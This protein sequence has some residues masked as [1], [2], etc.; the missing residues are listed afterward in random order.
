M[1][2]VFRVDPQ[3]M[4]IGMHAGSKGGIWGMS[5]LASDGDSLFF[6]TGNTSGAN[7]WSGGEAIILHRAGAQASPVSPQTLYKVIVFTPQGK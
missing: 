7:D 4:L 3:G 2:A 5:G 6:A 1:P